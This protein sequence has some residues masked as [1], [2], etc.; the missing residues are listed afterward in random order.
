MWP[1]SPSYKRVPELDSGFASNFEEKQ[2]SS[3]AS[4]STKYFLALLVIANTIALGL[5]VPL[6]G[7]QPIQQSQPPAPTCQSASHSHLDAHPAAPPTLAA[8]LPSLRTQDCGGTP[9]SAKAANCSFDL[10]SNSWMPTACYDSETDSEF[11]DWIVHPNRTRG[12]WPYF[13]SKSLEPST[14]I[15]DVE[16]LSS[17]PGDVWLWTTEEEHIAHCIFWARRIHR[18]LEGNFNWSKSVKNMEHTF[19][20][21]YEVLDNLLVNAP[22]R[23]VET[24]VVHFKVQYDT[25]A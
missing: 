18:A 23:K 25:C 6:L 5:L 11:R 8:T 3:R 15:A 9:T 19:H 20:C 4:K 2:E 1:L 13:T 21:A 7:P 12:A 17:M 10:L 16:A 14:H 22:L 24:G